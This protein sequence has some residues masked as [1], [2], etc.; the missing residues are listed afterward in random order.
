[1][2]KQSIICKLAQQSIQDE[3]DY[4]HTIDI[5]TLTDENSWLQ[6]DGASFVTLTQN[7]NLRG[8]IGS[9]EAHRPLI[10]DIIANAKSAAFRDSRFVKLT[11]DEFVNTD[12]EVSILTKPMTIEYTDIEDLKTKIKPHIHGVIL[13]F[14]ANRATFLP[15]VWDEL[16][17]FEIFFGHL[18]HKAG[19]PMDTFQNHPQIQ[20]Y[21]VEKFSNNS[22]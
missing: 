14:G 8:C 6:E 18:L 11:R 15:Q 5:R 12:I 13:Q 4:T 16:P 2:K 19:L 3:F 10:E 9:L 1:M 7:G 17:T 21:T 22:N 20:I